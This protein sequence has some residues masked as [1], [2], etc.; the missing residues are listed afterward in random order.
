MMHLVQAATFMV[1][2]VLVLCMRLLRLR[3][4][5]RRRQKDGLKWSTDRH[6]MTAILNDGLNNHSPGRSYSEGDLNA[7]PGEP[8][9]R[10]PNLFPNADDILLI[11]GAHTDL[12]RAA[13]MLDGIVE[14]P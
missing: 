1:L 11:D 13:Y 10:R 6:H 12:S 3:L 4:R 9:R 5:Q 14:S 7:T 8:F 2:G